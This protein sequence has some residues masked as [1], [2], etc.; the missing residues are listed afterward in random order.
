MR[1]SD[2]SSD[3]CSSVL[4]DRAREEGADTEQ[5]TARLPFVLA[6]LAA[7][8]AGWL[9]AGI[10]SPRLFDATVALL[11]VAAL[12]GVLPFGRH[13]DQRGAVA[14]AFAAS[15]ALDRKSTRLNSSH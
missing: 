9:A 8:L 15:A 1:I 12:I 2:G 14:P 4:A 7:V 10:E 6:G 13:A 5:R 3:V 11:G